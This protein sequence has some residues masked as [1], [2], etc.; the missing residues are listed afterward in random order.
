MT[1]FARDQ[2][3]ILY[4]APDQNGHMIESGG[5]N[6]RS[7]GQVD[8]CKSDGGIACQLVKRVK[9]LAIYGTVSEVRERVLRVRY[10][11]THVVVSRAMR[12]IMHDD[13]IESEFMRPVLL[14]SQSA[15]RRGGIGLQSRRSTNRVS[16]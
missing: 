5:I 14:T 4:N 3:A 11:Y 12:L 7:N 6:K 15:Q 13:Q 1:H 2:T 10:W 16:C 8:R 9:R